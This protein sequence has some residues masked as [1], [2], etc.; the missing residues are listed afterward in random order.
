MV[1]PSRC[2]SHLFTSARSFE[3]TIS[4]RSRLTTFPAVRSD[5]PCRKVFSSSRRS[6]AHAIRAA[7]IDR[8]G[9]GV[10]TS[11]VEL[12]ETWGKPLRSSPRETEVRSGDSLNVLPAVPRGI[13]DRRLPGVLACP[14][15][16]DKPGDP[17]IDERSSI[18][19]LYPGVRVPNPP[20]GD[21]RNPSTSLPRPP[22]PVDPLRSPD[23]LP[24]RGE[25]DRSLARAASAGPSGC[26]RMSWLIV[27]SRGLPKGLVVDRR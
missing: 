3:S 23:N 12:N 26:L 20:A 10:Y 4:L 15:I 2:E 9:F 14:T 8:S 22:P 6:P 24:G 7:S 19:C 1:M 13:G 5:N 21:P 11:A 27:S 16:P 17:E 25:T 18:P